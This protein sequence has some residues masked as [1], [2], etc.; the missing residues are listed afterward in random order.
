MARERVKLAA[1][2]CRVPAL[3]VDVLA[4][5][6]FAFQ[7]GP[8]AAALGVMRADKLPA[9]D[10]GGFPMASRVVLHTDSA[11]VRALAGGT[12]SSS[13]CAPL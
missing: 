2:A 1:G 3:L 11:C 10:A 6:N 8:M 12:L 9:R 7:P 13:C 4:A 5:L